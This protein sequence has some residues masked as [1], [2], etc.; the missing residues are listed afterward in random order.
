MQHFYDSNI[1]ILMHLL[2]A[3]QAKKWLMWSVFLMETSSVKVNISNVL[4]LHKVT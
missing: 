2:L 4:K 1:S 3:F